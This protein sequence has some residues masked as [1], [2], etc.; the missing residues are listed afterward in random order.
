MLFNQMTHVSTRGFVNP[1][2]QPE[3]FLDLDNVQEVHDVQLVDISQEG[4]SSHNELFIFLI[5][6]VVFFRFQA[7]LNKHKTKDSLRKIR[8][9]LT[10]DALQAEDLWSLNIF[11]QIIHL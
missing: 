5:I 11:M 6:V 3:H 8:K 2:F 1:I 4:L 9:R 7:H 10:M